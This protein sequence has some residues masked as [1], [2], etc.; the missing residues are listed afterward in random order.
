MLDALARRLGAEGATATV[1]R[2]IEGH[3][4]DVLEVVLATPGKPER[5]VMVKRQ[6]HADP[7]DPYFAWSPEEEFESLRRIEQAAGETPIAPRPLALLD[8]ERCLVLEKIEGE[9]FH[10]WLLSAPDPSRVAAVASR[11]GQALERLH[12]VGDTGRRR[13]VDVERH[14]AW[15]DDVER[16]RVLASS[17]IRAARGAM[18]RLAPA[19]DD[20]ELPVSLK[21]G[22]FQPANVIV[23]PGDAVRI[24]DISLTKEDLTVKDV[25]NFLVGVRGLRLRHLRLQLPLE[26]IDR[27]FVAAYYGSDAERIRPTLSFL[28]I[29]WWAQQCEEVCRR[30]GL[31]RRWW[32]RRFFTARILEAID[33]APRGGEL[34]VEP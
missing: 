27:A 19:V 1:V 20:D 33:S 30:S 9:A 8:D 14:L 4:S 18:R 24:I 12:A 25:C 3:R 17:T 22:D 11:I 6:K 34:G 26:E 32:A 29:L 2:R 28:S 21:H 16:A 7:D 31:L 5:R 23:E 13:S 10:R 15:L